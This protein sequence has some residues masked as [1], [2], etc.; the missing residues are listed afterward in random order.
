MSTSHA[1]NTA[2]GSS[3]L[4][5]LPAELRNSIYE[6]VFADVQDNVCI[7]LE[8]ADNK[9]ETRK[10]RGKKPKSTSNPDETSRLGLLL[11]CRKINTEASG[12]AFSKMSMSID[13]VFPVTQYTDIRGKVSLDDRGERLASI[14]GKV[15]KT[16]LGGNLGAI[17]TMV[18]PSTEILFELVKCNNHTM[19]IQRPTDFCTAKCALYSHYQGVVHNL[20][21]NVRRIVVGGEEAFGGY[22]EYLSK[23]ASWLSITMEPR[24]LKGVLNVFSNLEEI[25]VRRECGEQVSKVIDGK[26][27]AAESG[28]PMR[29]IDDWA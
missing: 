15:T 10:V 26:V 9:K 1:S 17:P 22:Y 16:F 28:M 29:G 14:L 24:D 6:Y 3:R 25:V 13:N 2:P 7:D 21:H 4:L 27:Y 20:F 19:D 23:G 12:I 5:T 11:T 18:F 8:R